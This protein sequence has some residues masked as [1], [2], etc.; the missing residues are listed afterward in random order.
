M[1]RYWRSILLVG[2]LA[3][4]LVG[5]LIGYVA[6]SQAHRP[7]RGVSAGVFSAATGSMCSP[8]RRCDWYGRATCR[9]WGAHSVR[10][11]RRA[12]DYRTILRVQ[13]NCHAVGVVDHRY[14]VI[15]RRQWCD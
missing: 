2:S 11:T 5:G 1:T 9:D 8:S 15:Q 13:W 3:A 10:C 14:R 4:L 6:V 7:S 12:V